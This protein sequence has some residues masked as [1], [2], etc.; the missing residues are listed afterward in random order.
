MKKQYIFL[1]ALSLLI[2]H[3]LTSCEKENDDLL[4][5][6][7]TFISSGT[8]D[9]T[10]WPTDEWR[11][12]HPSKVGMDAAKLAELNEEMNILLELHYYV[13][14]VLIVKD[15]YIVAEQY[16]S[17]YYN[18]DSL[19]PIYSCTKS[20]TSAMIGQ[21]IDMDHIPGVDALLTDFFS[22]SEILNLTEQ[23][24]QIRLE[25][26]LTMS[27]GFEWHE[28]EYSYSDDRNTFRQWSESENR[29]Q[30]LLDLPMSAAP[31]EEYAY[32]TGISH[33]LSAI[34]KAIT[35]VKSTPSVK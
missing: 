35:G 23:K 1:L 31:G 32:N 22:E 29:V 26:M 28:I 11:T 10:Y 3:I 33:A 9:G 7:N 8:Y 15:G 18:V 19:H 2:M 16:Y 24:K 20:L 12:C 13:N 14:S 30:F 17:D 4:F 27:A 6:N 21:A 25:H 34:I 5:P